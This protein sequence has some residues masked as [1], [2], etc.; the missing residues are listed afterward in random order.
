[1]VA[2]LTSLLFSHEVQMLFEKT[3]VVPDPILFD[4]AISCNL[5]TLEKGFIFLVKFCVPQGD[6]FQ[7]ERGTGWFL[8]G[9]RTYPYHLRK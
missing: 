8:Y 7:I 2:C 1:M 3:A 9:K 4:P 5:F 6:A